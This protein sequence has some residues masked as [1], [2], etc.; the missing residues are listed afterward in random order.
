MRHIEPEQVIKTILEEIGKET[1]IEIEIEISRDEILGREVV[2]ILMISDH[3]LDANVYSDYREIF[4]KIRKFLEDKLTVLYNV[5]RGKPDI[6]MQQIN[7]EIS[8]K[9]I[10]T[11]IEI[12]GFWTDKVRK[13]SEIFLDELESE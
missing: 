1:G 5:V 6:T 9:Q 8:L 4:S 7:K 13:E 2:E 3:D 11:T 12:L 10:R